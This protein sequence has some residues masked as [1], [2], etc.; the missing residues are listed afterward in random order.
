MITLWHHRSVSRQFLLHGGCGLSTRA[1]FRAGRLQGS[2]SSSPAHK[3]EK[4]GPVGLKGLGY[5]PAWL[6]SPPQRGPRPY[7]GH[8]L[9]LKLHFR[10]RIQRSPPTAQTD[11]RDEARRGGRLF[12]ADP[13]HRI[14]RA[15]APRTACF[16]PPRCNIRPFPCPQVP[17]RQGFVP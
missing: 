11:A 3:T 8:F 13:G 16:S 2:A 10:S 9:L 15:I 12:S 17:R 1:V 4:T 14:M 5:P 6:H 7:M